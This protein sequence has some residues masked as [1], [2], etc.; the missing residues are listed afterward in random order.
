MQVYRIY[1]KKLNPPPA[2]H[3]LSDRIQHTIHRVTV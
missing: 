1:L 3:T 2:Y